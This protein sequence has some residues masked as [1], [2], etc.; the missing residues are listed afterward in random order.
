M[1]HKEQI[2]SGFRVLTGI[3]P[4]KSPGL[5]NVNDG[6]FQQAVLESPFP[7]LTGFLASWDGVSKVMKPMLERIAEENPGTLRVAMIDVD[8]SPTVTSTYA[9]QSVPTLLMFTLGTEERR[10]SGSMTKN[11][12]NEFVKPYV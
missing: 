6:N 12:L 11:A 3:Q 9:I 1:K 7:V 8:Q 2:R 5:V 4:G 10:A